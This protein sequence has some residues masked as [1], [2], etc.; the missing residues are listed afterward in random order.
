[1]WGVTH[2]RRRGQGGRG[3]PAARLIGK[4][5]TVRAATPPPSR[6]ATARFEPLRMRVR[7]RVKARARA[8]ARTRARARARAR[9][10]AKAKARARARVRVKVRTRVRVS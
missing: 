10:S 8:R 6:D 9:A 5:P 1:M 2:L 7:A 3:A 4:W